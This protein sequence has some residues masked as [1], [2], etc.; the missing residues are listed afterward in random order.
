MGRATP[1]T[2]KTDGALLAPPCLRPCGAQ[3]SLHASGSSCL[4]VYGYLSDLGSFR[5]LIEEFRTAYWFLQIS[6]AKLFIMK[7]PGS[8]GKR[9]HICLLLYRSSPCSVLLAGMNGLYVVLPTPFC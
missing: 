8:S 6:T 9:R 2:D 1:K 5:G 7:L 3:T 4:L